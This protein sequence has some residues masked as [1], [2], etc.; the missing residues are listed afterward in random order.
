MT[1]CWWFPMEY[2]TTWC[3]A[4]D[5]SLLFGVMLY[6]ER[7]DIESSQPCVVWLEFVLAS[8]ISV[9]YSRTANPRSSWLLNQAQ[10]SRWDGSFYR[11]RSVSGRCNQRRRLR[12][13][14]DSSLI[15]SLTCISYHLR[16]ELGQPDRCWHRSVAAPRSRSRIPEHRVTAVSSGWPHESR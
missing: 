12:Y 15:L 4:N 14:K 9:Q 6:R 11:R 2:T 8:H 13:N 16:L 5:I 7:H 10:D 3:C 1:A